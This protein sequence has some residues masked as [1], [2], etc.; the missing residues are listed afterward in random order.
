MAIGDIIIGIDIG[1]SKVCTV[2]GE[3]NNFGQIETI[4][5][6]SEKCGGLKKGKII[7]EEEI[8][9]SIAKTIKDAED[10]ADFK[11]NSAYVTIPGK[12][13]TIVQNSVVKELKDKF[14]GISLKD[15]QSAMMQAKDIEIPEG[16]TIIDIVPSEIVLDNGKVVTDQLAGQIMQPGE[17]KEVT[18]LLTWINREDNMGLKVNVAEI[19]KDYNE[20]GTPDI[21]STPNNKVPGEDDIDDA[22]VML[23]VTTGEKVMYLGIYIAVLAVIA[24]GIYGV[25][26]YI[27]K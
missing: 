9:L 27:I 19:S 25:K 12:Y 22:P 2:V 10:E 20:Y 8:S 7:N 11:I 24:V 18:I 1:T 26:K 3:V 13:V 16:K 21:D 4:C 6:T 14:A 15:V 17:S 5:S 23:T